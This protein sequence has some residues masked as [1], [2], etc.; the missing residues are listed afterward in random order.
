MSDSPIPH[1]DTRGRWGR[2]RFAEGRVHAL[3]VAIPSGVVLSLGAGAVAMQFHVEKVPPLLLGAVF[4]F[5]TVF[6]LI[7][8]IWALVVDRATVRGTLDRPEESIESRWWDI[9]AQGAFTDTI[10]ITGLGLTVI[11][12]T[13]API[14][15]VPALS[16]VIIVA[17]ISSGTRYLMARKRG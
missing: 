8:L 17:F 14:G 11:A 6:P 5:A 4:A 15:A 3:S 16:A 2:T 13:N 1:P 12:L 7:G 9:A 10:T